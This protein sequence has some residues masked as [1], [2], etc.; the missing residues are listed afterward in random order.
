MVVTRGGALAPPSQQDLGSP[1]TGSA[2][3]APP[4]LSLPARQVL[5]GAAVAGGGGWNQGARASLLGAL[6]PHN[7]PLP[8]RGGHQG[9]ERVS[10]W[11]DITQL[12]RAGPGTLTPSPEASSGREPGPGRRGGPL[13]SGRWAPSIAPALPPRPWLCPSAHALAPFR[14]APSGRTACSSAGLW[15]SAGSSCSSGLS[16]CPGSRP[17]CALVPQSPGCSNSHLS[18]AGCQRWSGGRG[19]RERQPGRGLVLPVMEAP[20]SRR[21]Q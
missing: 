14:P 2:G 5:S 7:I 17:L 21:G 3:A 15:P 1:P 19:G 12:V 9:T 20:H 16:V 10:N 18:R 4:R 13:C 8:P 6:S 11:L